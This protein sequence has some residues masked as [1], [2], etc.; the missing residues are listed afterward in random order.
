MK[1]SLFKTS[2]YGNNPI[3]HLTVDGQG[4]VMFMG[5]E[6]TQ[7]KGLHR[8]RVSPEKV[9]QLWDKLEAVSITTNF[10]VY[11]TV[12]KQT[13]SIIILNYGNMAD[14]LQFSAKHEHS[15][16]SRAYYYM[17]RLIDKYLASWEY[18]G[19]Q[20]RFRIEKITMPMFE[21]GFELKYEEGNDWNLF[22]YHD[23]LY[24]PEKTMRIP[25]QQLDDF[26]EVLEYYCNDWGPL[27]SDPFTID[28]E[29][30][31]ID[32]RWKGIDVYTYCENKYPPNF[33]LFESMAY[34]LIGKTD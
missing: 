3:Y 13:E 12:E 11:E 34:T 25:K 23:A 15:D 10:K 1:I 31:E 32:V 20:Y 22:Y 4:Q 6:N 29:C 28:G 17:E 33:K 16:L 8:W 2:V 5:F 18:V 24:G 21:S 9:K 19:N 7:K 27:Y 30:W 14:T 26:L